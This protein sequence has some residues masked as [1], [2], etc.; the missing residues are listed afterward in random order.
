MRGLKR[1]WAITEEERNGETSRADPGESQ[2]FLNA[3]KA[4][5]AG[6]ASCGGD[7]RFGEPLLDARGY[8]TQMPAGGEA[9]WQSFI[10][11]S[12]AFTKWRH[13]EAGL[14]WVVYHFDRLVW[15]F[16]FD[17]ARRFKRA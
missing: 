14:A 5:T 8:P 15:E 3:C 7:V 13:M 1:K 2:P 12:M 4:S 9:A 10:F 16:H 11:I 6:A 17:N